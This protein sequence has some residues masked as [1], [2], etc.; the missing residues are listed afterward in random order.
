MLSFLFVS[1][2]SYR[3]CPNKIPFREDLYFE[4]TVKG[5]HWSYFTIKLNASQFYMYF[6]ISGTGNA[7]IYMGRYNR[8]P[9][10]NDKPFARIIG[11]ELDKPQYVRAWKPSTNAFPIGIYAEEESK[12]R[13]TI[14]PVSFEFDYLFYTKWALIIGISL[15]LVVQFAR[16]VIPFDEMFATKGKKHKAKSRKPK[17]KNQQKSTAQNA[18]P[19]KDNPS[20]PTK[21]KTK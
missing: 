20:T 3:I 4:K 18:T 6:N 2:F 11:G 13:I 10:K 16:G 7:S 21:V 15:F 5:E 9:Y 17:S 8:C 19:S 12:V 14:D 1:T